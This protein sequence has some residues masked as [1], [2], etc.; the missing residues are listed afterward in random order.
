MYRN[1]D[2]TFGADPEGLP[3]TG[4]QK[5]R[6]QIYQFQDYPLV[7][8]QKSLR[9]DTGQIVLGL[10]PFISPCLVILL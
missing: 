7:Q 9:C 1:I 5:H 3:F 6:H 8:T 2:V 4:N 10:L